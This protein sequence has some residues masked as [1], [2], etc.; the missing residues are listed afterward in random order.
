MV[1]SP[2]D[3]VAPGV[4][5]EGAGGR[6]CLELV[7]ESG[8]DGAV[9]VHAGGDHAAAELTRPPTGGVGGLG[10]EKI[11]EIGFRIAVSEFDKHVVEVALGIGAK[12]VDAVHGLLFDGGGGSVVD[13]IESCGGSWKQGRGCG[14]ENGGEEGCFLVGKRIGR[15]HNRLDFDESR[16]T[17]GL[18]EGGQ[19][20]MA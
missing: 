18:L 17:W 19:E 2:A 13:G 5:R 9:E 8:G 6:E 15:Q 7:V 12:V 20:A 10:R 4:A 3:I 14:D 11:V 1:G 16:N